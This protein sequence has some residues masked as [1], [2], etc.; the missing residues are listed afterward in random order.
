[1]ENTRYCRYCSTPI[2]DTMRAD[3]NYCN[4]ICRSSF[5]K[6]KKPKSVGVTNNESQSVSISRQ[7][8]PIKS[9]S[10]AEYHTLVKRIE[11]LENRLKKLE[12]GGTDRQTPDY[13]P[14]NMKYIPIAEVME[15]YSVSRSV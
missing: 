11:D 15:K 4:P 6:K 5:H 1:M 8:I 2:P 3:A 12:K 10:V 9:Q 7:N 14:D 13:D